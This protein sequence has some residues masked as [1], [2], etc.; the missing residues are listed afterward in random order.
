[1]VKDLISNW[2]SESK[3]KIRSPVIG[4]FIGAWTLLNWKHFLLL[5]WGNG[6]IETRLANFETLLIFSN[7][8]FWLW[9]ILIALVYAFCLP[10]LNILSQII[11]RKAEELGHQ[12]TINVDIQ[13]AKQKLKLNE[14]IY[15]ADPSNPFLGKK[16]E[17]DLKRIQADA[18][19]TQANAEKS[20]AVADKAAAELATTKSAQ[21][22]NEA[23]A[24]LE[25][26]ELK[27]LKRRD[28]REQQAHEGAKITHQHRLSCLRF[29]LAYQYI[30]K[31]SDQ[32]V[33]NQQLVKMDTL[34]DAIATAFGYQTADKLL[35]DE[36]FNQENLETLSFVYYESKQLLETLRLI[37]Q[38]DD[39]EDLDEELLFDCLIETFEKLN[40]C[41]LLSD[42]SIEEEASIYIQEHSYDIINFDEV[43]QT[44]A[45]TNAFFD[46]V[47]IG[48]PDH[49][50]F[51]SKSKSYKLG[52]SGTVFGTNHENKVFSGDTLDVSFT[53]IY[54][55][56]LGGSGLGK[57]AF[58]DISASV[59]HPDNHR[60]K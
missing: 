5:F 28:E 42:D 57:P 51:N 9:P 10:Y 18:E 41:K 47:S 19:N 45:E 44:M 49:V 58:K 4:A 22:K 43:I 21:E 39:N 52:F 36:K 25:A 3:T 11:L 33:E 50:T 27:D 56:E 16:I 53:L 60:Y 1:M 38:N 26:L 15:K 55:V 37:A 12:Q 31:L 14:E 54:P 2:F 6:L 24:K 8:S 40:Y 32:L 29:P 20:R 35:N 48:K 59:S 23:E 46:E 7:L 34:A 30:K 13:K 17:A